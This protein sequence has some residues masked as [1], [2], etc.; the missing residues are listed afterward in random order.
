MEAA[1]GRV[2]AA[3]LQVCIIT[4]Q[5]GPRCWGRKA[6]LQLGQGVVICMGYMVV[7][8]RLAR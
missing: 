5:L 2:R 3:Q 1:L 6:A 8:A 7:A 4:V